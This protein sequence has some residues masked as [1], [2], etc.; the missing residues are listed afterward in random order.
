V[1][2][3]GGSVVDYSADTIALMDNVHPN[4]TGYQTMAARALPVYNAALA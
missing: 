2:G 1:P 4:S 3:L